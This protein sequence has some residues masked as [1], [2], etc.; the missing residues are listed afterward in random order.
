VTRP[1]SVK[2]ITSTANPVI[3]AA[4]ALHQRKA[5]AESGLFLAEGRKLILDA[6][7]VGWAPEMI[8]A[9][10]PKDDGGK[11]ADL[12]AKVRAAGADVVFTSPAVMEK[13]ARRDNPQTV[14]GIFPQRLAP[15]AAF[16]GG[17][18][19]ALE[20]PRDP[21][22]V[23]TI[24]RTADAAGASGV[25]LVG[26]SADPFGVEAVRATMGSL[27]HAPVARVEADAFHAF[28]NG[29]PGAVIGTHL[30]ATVDIRS[31]APA[32]PQILVMGTEQAGLS[33]ALAARCD[34]L[35]RIPMAGKADSLN[36]AVAT[37]LA[38]YELRRPVLP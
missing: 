29:W 3:K 30:A 28:L 10:E 12:A 19:V 16:T 26:P 4:R 5:R 17:T 34:P 8:I 13:I 2:H 32:E 14:L 6:L 18:V 24:V 23:G 22:N 9:L 35:V 36:L 1:G 7:S 21:G 20:G 37:A 15:L 11:E 38:L 31:L 25:I 33:D 27:F